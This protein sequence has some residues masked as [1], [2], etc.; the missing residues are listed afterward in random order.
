MARKKERRGPRGGRTTVSKSG[1]VRKTLWI[2]EDENEAL[3][4]AAFDRRTS[5]TEIVRRL[6]REHF[7]IED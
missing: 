3:R 1:L 5:E 2:H 6:L 7:Q 4:Q